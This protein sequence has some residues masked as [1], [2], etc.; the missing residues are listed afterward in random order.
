MFDQERSTTHMFEYMSSENISLRI[1]PRIRIL[2]VEIRDE[3]VT[4]RNASSFL[5]LVCHQRR[6][7]D[8]VVSE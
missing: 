1:Q 8:R 2:K 4:H 5:E 7:A 6:V 3:F